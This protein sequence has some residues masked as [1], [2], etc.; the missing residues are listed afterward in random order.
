MKK[1]DTSKNKL[2]EMVLLFFICIIVFSQLLMQIDN[3]P[4]TPDDASI[5]I[6]LG[7]NI[8]SGQGYVNTFSHEKQPCAKYP[9]V[10]PLL[11]SGI[12]HLWGYNYFIMRLMNAL[13]LSFSLI[14]IYI[15]M[16]RRTDAFTA[17]I[18][19]LLTA[20]SFFVLY[21][22]FLIYSEIA[23]IFF[24]ILGLIFVERYA[25]SKNT[26]SLSL[27][28]A[29]FFVIC[30]FFTRIIGISLVIA[31]CLFLL[32][33]RRTQSRKT[34]LQQFVVVGIITLL[35]VFLWF[36]R[37]YCIRSTLAFSY[38]GLNI[39]GFNK[40]GG[41]FLGII[42]NLYALVFCA[43][44]SIISSISIEQRS[45]LGFLLSL[46]MLWGV[47]AKFVKTKTIVEYYFGVY[48]C[49]LLFWNPTYYSKRLLVPIVPFV[50]YYFVEGIYCLLNKFRHCARIDRQAI[51]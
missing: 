5:Y 33:E 36:L 28:P 43:F 46:I 47:G 25:F 8:A 29:V 2:K 4:P 13:L 40:A 14:L 34:S 32:F 15:L 49:I 27:I 22:V 10:F 31:T 17:Y 3:F 44:P 42:K 23:Y 39:S 7:A 51:R 19:V 9:F 37:E 50:F 11:L 24:S 1:S 35:P 18:I 38:I 12:I 21:Y 6:S 30:A 48:I 45:V 26:F 20:T 16:K 41:F